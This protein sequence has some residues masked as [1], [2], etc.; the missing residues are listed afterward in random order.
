LSLYDWINPDA[1][2]QAKPDFYAYAG[3]EGG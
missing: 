2:R 1:R 3:I